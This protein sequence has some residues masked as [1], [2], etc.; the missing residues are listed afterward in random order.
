MLGLRTGNGRVEATEKL[1]VEMIV[2]PQPAR[3]FLR[4]GKRQRLDDLGEKRRR[5]Q[6][7]PQIDH[8]LRKLAELSVVAEL[9]VEE[10]E[11]L[12]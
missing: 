12:N 7:G 8:L 2:D 9:R 1:F 6:R 3:E 10:A 5:S 4:L 11:H